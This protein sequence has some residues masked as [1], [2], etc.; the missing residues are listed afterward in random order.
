MLFP[1][2]FP[3]FCQNQK[4]SDSGRKPW[5]YTIIVFSLQYYIMQRTV[6][7][8]SYFDSLDP[9]S[10]QSQH[11]YTELYST[12]LPLPSGVRASLPVHKATLNASYPES[13][14]WRTKNAVGSVKTQVV[15][16][17]IIILS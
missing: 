7:N 5:T 3:T 6:S 13:L 1:M 8:C 11:E 15:A 9:P 4:F 2:A 12:H 16:I 17:I 10:S 14:D